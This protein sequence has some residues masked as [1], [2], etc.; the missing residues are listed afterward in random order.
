MRAVA[1][2]LLLALPAVAQDAADDPVL[3]FTEPVQVESGSHV[4]T[5]PPG[6]FLT[7]RQMQKLDT[8][9]QR[10]QSREIDLQ[11]QNKNLGETLAT[12]PRGGISLKAVAICFVA[13]LAVG[14]TASVLL[15]TR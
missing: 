15:I 12:P 3:Q 13:G 8:E 6:F 2:L 11:A 14:A 10:L 1:L 4:L 9:V 5:L 7:N